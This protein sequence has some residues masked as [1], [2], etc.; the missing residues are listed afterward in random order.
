LIDVEDGL[1]EVRALPD[2]DIRLPNNRRPTAA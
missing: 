2:A 1:R